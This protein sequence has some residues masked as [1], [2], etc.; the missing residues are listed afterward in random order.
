MRRPVASIAPLSLAQS[1]A[2]RRERRS[3]DST[4]STSPCGHPTASESSS[5]R[6]AVAPLAF[7]KYSQAMTLLW[8]LANSPGRPG[9]GRRFARRWM[10]GGGANEHSPTCIS[11]GVFLM[12]LY[13]GW[14]LSSEKADK[15]SDCPYQL[16]HTS[17]NMLVVGSVVIRKKH[18]CS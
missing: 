13:F 18:G 3:M 1:S 8:S 14:Y 15:G 5:G 12:L 17:R 4:K 2:G 9:R 11:E 6:S 16:R 10:L 7:S